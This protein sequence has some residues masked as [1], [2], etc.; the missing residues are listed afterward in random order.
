MRCVVVIAIGLAAPLALNAQLAPLERS[1]PWRPAVCGVARVADSLAQR[2]DRAQA[3]VVLQRALTPDSKDADAWHRYGVLLWQ[4]TGTRRDGY[5]GDLTTIRTLST[6]DSA[7]RM[8][9]KLASDRAE[10]WATLARFNLDSSAGSVRFAASQEWERAAREAERAGDTAQ[11][12]LAAAEGGLAA[13]RRYLAIRNRALMSEGRTIRLQTNM[14]WERRLA[15]DYVEAYVRR[16]APPTGV[17]EYESVLSR[18]RRAER[19]APASLRNARLLY[20][21]LAD[22]NRWGELLSA[23]NRRAATSTFDGQARFERG[24]ALV[25]LGQ[26]APARTA[27][28][29]ALATLDDARDPDASTSYNELELEFLARVTFAE[30][31]WSNDE[32]GLHGADTERAEIYLRYGPPDEILTIAGA[33]S[34]ISNELIAGVTQATSSRDDFG[35]TLLWFCRNGTVVFFDLPAGYGTARMPNVDRGYIRDV[36]RASPLRWDNLA[37]PAE[38]D[39]SLLRVM[40]FRAAADA[41]ELLVLAQ[42]PRAALRDSTFVAADSALVSL[43]L[44][45]DRATVATIASDTLPLAGSPLATRS[46]VTRQAARSGI[47]QISS[48]VPEPVHLPLC[49]RNRSRSTTSGGGPAPIV[50]VLPSPTW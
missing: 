21:A 13:W 12:T 49:S 9:T 28:D 3:L 40:R 2:G 24:L 29:S 7:L 33:A 46:W 45:D 30:F 34:V 22:G 36:Q 6:A 47:L 35:S 20:M 32:L 48:R 50:L 10:Y 39:S 8:A 25:R 19:L 11:I 16:I 5:M 4:S 23:A 26:L 27:F 38:V 1:D 43:R 14:R 41:V 37:L 31:A 42:V 15:R 18:F 17:S 44:V